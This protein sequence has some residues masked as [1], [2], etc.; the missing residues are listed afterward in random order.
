MDMNLAGRVAKIRLAPNARNSLLPLF[1]AIVNSIQSVDSAQP[2]RGTIDIAIERDG[3]QGVLA[4]ADGQ[5]LD[6]LHIKSFSISDNGIGFDDANFKSFAEA[7]T[8]YKRNIG[9]QGVGRLMWLKTFSDVRV[10]SIFGSDA[11][12]NRTFG[13]NLAANGICDP[14]VVSTKAV[15]RRTVVTLKD[16]LSEYKEACP[17]RVNTLALHIVDHCVEFLAMPKVPKITLSDPVTQTTIDL[18]HLFNKDLKLS[19]QTTRF[20]LKGKDFKLNH[21]F[22]RK[23][24]DT[25]HHLHFC[26]HDRPA[27]SEPLVDHISNLPKSLTDETTGKSMIYTG[28]LSSSYLNECVMAERTDFH[29]T[30]N[31][32][33]P[34]D[35]DITWDEMVVRAV[36][37]AKTVLEPHLAPIAKAKDEQI[38]RYVEE[39][40]YQYRPLYLHRK[41]LLESIPPGLAEPALDLELYKRDQEYG[42]EL[43][44]RAYE[45]LEDTGQEVGDFTEHQQK[46]SQFLQEWN[47]KGKH[48]LA[49]YVA[50]R[51]AILSYFAE[52]L[53]RRPD[54]KYSIEEDVHRIIFPLRKTSADVSIEQMN[55]WII[56]ERLAFHRYLS[57]DKYLDNIE[58]IQSD[59]HL[60][61]DL[62]IFDQ[63]F[64]F[65]ETSQNFG[66]IVIVEFKRPMRDDY[67]DDKNP[68][69]QVLEYIDRIKQGTAIARDGRPMGAVNPNTPFYAYVICDLTE[70][71]RAYAK[72]GGLIL[73]PDHQGFFG[74]NPSY[75][76]YI[77]VISFDKLI[78]DAQ[79]RNAVFFEKL[80]LGRELLEQ[81]AKKTE[82]S[83][84][85]SESPT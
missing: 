76:A 8:P 19:S 75:G 48:Q 5:K 56:D 39:K 23:T 42:R 52:Q 78:L 60:R 79:K 2:E 16:M 32:E 63:P 83:S 41:D 10:D 46:V 26:A 72:S 59:A 40:A 36:E 4:T 66:G 37:E 11:L 85:G 6:D 27:R 84:S 74:Y 18:N 50:H 80:N 35:G 20:R 81:P 61:P 67:K 53:R 55:L 57:S 15:Q 64:A 58:P 51:K 82:D 62:L 13:F 29:Q 45:I 31:G 47:D 12:Q 22:M 69:M 49:V 14:M 7:D 68:I 54:G 1:E 77:E 9:G 30:T 3:F 44:Q 25:P 34:F 21:I 28:Y 70:K 65:S 38:R 71:M 24:H 43:K 17:R 73:T 33:L